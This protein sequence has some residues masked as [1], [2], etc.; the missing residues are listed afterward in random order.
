MGKR[1]ESISENN[2]L[3]W[4]WLRGL[5]L[6]G[7]CPESFLKKEEKGEGLE[8]GMDWLIDLGVLVVSSQYPQHL[9]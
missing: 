7:G 8:A 6:M 2:C 3:G 5:P 9:E 4:D 1:L